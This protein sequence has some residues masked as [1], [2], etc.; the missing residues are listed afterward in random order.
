[1][2]NTVNITGKELIDLGF[3]SGKWFPEAIEYINA[4]Q[5]EGETMNAFL[6]QYR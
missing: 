4:N 6:E 3:R 5:L 2:K 1:M